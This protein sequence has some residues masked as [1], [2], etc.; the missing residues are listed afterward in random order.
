MDATCVSYQMFD[1]RIS[2]LINQCF[3]FQVAYF[4]GPDRYH[5]SY[6]IRVKAKDLQKLDQ[7][8]SGN[9]ENLDDL[10]ETMTQF[11]ALVRINE[12]ASKVTHS[13]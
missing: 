1:L 7:E 10:D 3:F 2:N 6:S 8:L 9:A 5:A 13:L 4:E 11:S 12:T